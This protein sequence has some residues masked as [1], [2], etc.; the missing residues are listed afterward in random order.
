[1]RCKGRHNWVMPKIGDAGLTCANPDC[2]RNRRPLRF[3]S[4]ITPNMANRILNGQ[5]ALGNSHYEEFRTAFYAAWDASP[6]AADRPPLP[7]LSPY[8]DP[9]KGARLPKRVRFA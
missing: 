5:L 3:R 8:P 9:H 6:E 2:N 1:M 4:D 7:P